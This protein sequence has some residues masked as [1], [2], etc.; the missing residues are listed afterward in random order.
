[1]TKME[2]IKPVKEPT[3]WVSSVVSYKTKWKNTS[4]FRS[5][6]SKQSNKKGILLTPKA[7]EIFAEMQNLKFF[8]N[9]DASN[10]YWLIKVD[11]ESS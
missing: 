5:K 8:T 7:K 4:M 2:I 11:E 6:R 3:D 1:M 9:L 10:R